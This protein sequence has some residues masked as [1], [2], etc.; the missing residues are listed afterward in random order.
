[1]R[2]KETTLTLVEFDN[3]QEDNGDTREKMTNL[4]EIIGRSVLYDFAQMNEQAKHS[5]EQGEVNSL[6]I[7][8]SIHAENTGKLRDVG[9]MS[10]NQLVP[11]EFL[12]IFSIVTKKIPKIT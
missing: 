10:V 1:M 6:D 2:W 11:M 4:R 7:N 12:E 8:S 3:D 9:N 5:E